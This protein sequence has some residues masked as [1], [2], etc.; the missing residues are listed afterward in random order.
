M[1]RL[2]RPAGIVLVLSLVLGL[3]LASASTASAKIYWSKADVLRSFFADC[4]KVTYEKFELDTE[5]RLHLR[6]RLG[7]LPGAKKLTVYYGLKG[8]QVA[9][10]AIIDNERGQ[11][12]P[13]TF[14]LLMDASGHAERLEV[15]V[16]REAYG[17]EIRQARFR[18]QFEG[19]SVTDSVR[20]GRDITA[21]SGATISSK[22]M[23]RGV[24]RALTLVDELIVKPGVRLAQAK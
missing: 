8:G 22:A 12:E 24:K 19:K 13:I 18:R 9:G 15:M 20:Q 17:D 3:L 1:R 6:K 7:Y 4:E 21:V 5:T 16:Y 11:H 10:Y 2:P 14:A 23:A